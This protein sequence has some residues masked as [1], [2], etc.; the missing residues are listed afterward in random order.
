MT[1]PHPRRTAATLG[2]AAAGLTLGHWLAY[3]LAA[4]GAHAREQLLHA[5]GHGYLAFAT[6][7]ALLAGGLGLVAL[8][9]ARCSHRE[10]RG[11][12]GSDAAVLAAVQSITFVAME[13]GERLAS[14]ASLHDL[15]HGG[16][17]TIGLAVQIS[18]AIAGAGALRLTDR[19][20]EV[21]ETLREVTPARGPRP[22]ATVATVSFA[23]PRRPAM[24]TLASRAPPA[25]P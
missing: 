18:V 13:V 2:I 3:A 25:L 20:A 10:G 23:A 16:L 8:F 24:R 15:T 21:V 19:A 1:A 4:P 6:Q 11:S 7:V 22:V 14:G 5:T 17:L 12:F 9:L